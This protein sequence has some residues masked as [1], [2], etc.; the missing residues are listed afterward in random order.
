MYTL[1]RIVDVYALE[2]KCYG[3]V[4]HFDLNAANHLIRPSSSVKSW[5]GLC[6]G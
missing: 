5:A 3:N 4:M 1:P 6:L 2:N